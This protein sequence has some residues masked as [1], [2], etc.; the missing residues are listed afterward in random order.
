[1]GDFICNEAPARLI[2][3]DELM[4]LHTG[5][6]YWLES[7]DK[8]PMGRWVLFRTDW[9]VYKREEDHSQ[10]LL[11]FAGRNLKVDGPWS[12]VDYNEEWRLWNG[13]PDG[14]Q[15]MEEAWNDL[16]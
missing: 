8:H 14:K 10:L 16:P 11:Y 9:F 13:A 2:T 5:D 12:S 7:R 15:T 3:K 4:K 6:P 1:M